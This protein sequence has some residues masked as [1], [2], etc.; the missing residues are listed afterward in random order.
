MSAEII[1]VLVILVATVVMLVV[2]VIRIDVVALL[3]MLALG[4]M[5]ILDS[6]EMLSGFS[7]T[8]V[9]A[10][11]AVMI[12]GHGVAK[13][14]V[15]D[16]FSRLVLAK[17]GTSKPKIIG[18]MSLSVGALSGFVQN[19]GAAALFLPGVL[20]I[21]R[22]GKIP[23]SSL[24]MPIGFAAILGGTL[25]MVGSGHLILTNDLLRAADLEPFGLFAVMP[26]GALLLVAGIVFFVFFGKFFLPQSGSAGQ[27]VGEQGRLIKALGLPE[28][29]RHCRVGEGSPLSGKRPE[30]VGLWC[31]Y[32]LNL[33]GV[34]QGREVHYAPW[35]G[36][37]FAAGQVLALLGKEEDL[38]RFIADFALDSVP[39]EGE[40]AALADPE[41]SGFAEVVVPPRSELVGQSIRAYAV[42]KRHAVEPLMLWSKGEAMRGDFSDQTIHAGDTLVV[43]GL[44]DRIADLKESADFI[45]ATSFE[46]ARKDSSK[47]FLALG[48]FVLSIVLALFGFPIAMAFLTGALVMVLGRV[49]DIQEAYKAIEWKVVFLLAGLIPLG[50]A[51]QK[52]GAAHF[53][54]EQVMGLVLGRDPIW[55]VITVAVLATLF[56]L[57]MTNVGAIVVLA[58]LVISMAQIGDVDPRALTLLAAICAGNSFILPTHQVNALLMS[59]GGYGNR[60]YFRAG[61]GMTVVF[62]IVAVAT[63]GLFY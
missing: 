54:A 46:H 32:G 37:R 21:A 6:R 38:S 18:L 63:F 15:M 52:S 41:H 20:N 42:R 9:I 4:W 14:G 47:T 44:W 2:D 43:H 19:I 34:Q 45:V 35:R 31:T 60:D 30:D 51:M 56:S 1:I 16:R 39:L 40:L 59:A 8:A 25:S 53:L 29:R 28:G 3:C 48:A 24:I 7:S 33:L 17:V 62:L 57:F 61:G 10:M 55:L 50:I 11:I 23:A 12:M 36:T 13:T 49:M 27:E 58:P 26:V 5:G 22:R